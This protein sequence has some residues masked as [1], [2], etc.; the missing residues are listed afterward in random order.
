MELQQQLN[1]L[2]IMLDEANRNNSSLSKK[3]DETTTALESKV[4]RLQNGLAYLAQELKSVKENSVS[5][6]E[7]QKIS[8]EQG[9]K[10]YRRVNDSITWQTRHLEANLAKADR[11]EETYGGIRMLYNKA[12]PLLEDIKYRR[13]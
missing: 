1:Q 8:D 4:D 10:V 7:V 9:E 3:L 5:K 6:E 13:R 2:I 11:L 12:I